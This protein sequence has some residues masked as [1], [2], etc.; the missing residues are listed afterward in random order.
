MINYL[1]FANNKCHSYVYL[2]LRAFKSFYFDYYG[3]FDCVLIDLILVSNDGIQCVTQGFTYCNI[4]L[5]NSKAALYKLC[6]YMVT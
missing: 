6:S 1:N 5:I 4:K 3:S 2:I